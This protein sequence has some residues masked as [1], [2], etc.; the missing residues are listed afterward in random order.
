MVHFQ[1]R[2]GSSLRTG[3]LLFFLLSV[4]SA[5]LFVEGQ[6][7]QNLCS[8]QV[9]IS[10]TIYSKE[11]NSIEITLASKIAVGW[12]GVGIGGATNGMAGNDLAICWPNAA[13]T[14]ASIS[15]RAAT[16]NGTPTVVSSSV[17]FTVVTEKSK[18]DASTKAF[19]CT[20]TRPLS[21][22]TSTIPSSATSINVIFAIGLQAVQGAS[23][24]PQQATFQKHTYTGTG[25]LP[26]VKKEGSG[27]NTTTPPPSGG[28]NGDGSGGSDV[29]PD[30]LIENAKQYEKL[31]KAHGI[32]MAITFLFIFPLGAFLVR[33]FSHLGHVFRWHRPIQVLGFLSAVAGFACIMGAV[34]KLPGGPPNIGG[35]THGAFGVFLLAAIVLQVCMGIFIFHTFDPNR[36]PDKFH[37][38]TWMHRI[39]GYAV[40]ICGIVQIHYGIDR[41]GQWPSRTEAIWILFHVWFIFLGV[42]FVGGTILK[43]VL[44][45]RRRGGLDV[46][47]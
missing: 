29:D 37:V 28:G 10:A 47:Q 16:R 42:V 27:G 44:A 20:F 45:R 11:P 12:L 34:N 40:L 13:G 23:G 46:K 38:P 15:Q 35:T 2:D 43:L 24:D 25:V 5:F 14:G 21:L 4:L 18:V 9:C 31:V 33:F 30:K 41:Y 32:I 1:R 26:I 22:S 19:T 3:W 8:S 17:A 6:Q 36:D 39:W 7:S